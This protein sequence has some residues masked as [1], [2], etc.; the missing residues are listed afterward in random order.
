[1]TKREFSPLGLEHLIS[2]VPIVA[3]LVA[4]DSDKQEQIVVAATFV[5]ALAVFIL[6]Y[7]HIYLLSM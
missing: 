1:M 2:A 3:H 5:S 6:F 4:K 7:G